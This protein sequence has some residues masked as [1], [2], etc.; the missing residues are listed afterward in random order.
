MK[1]QEEKRVELVRGHNHKMTDEGGES[2]RSNSDDDFIR[3]KVARE[4][5]RMNLGGL[6]MKL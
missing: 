6:I 4:K 3:E 1:I 5:E 2:E